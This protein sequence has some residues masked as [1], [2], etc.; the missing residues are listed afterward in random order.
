MARDEPMTLTQDL[1]Q[2]ESDNQRWA[3]DGG[4]APDPRPAPPDTL[5]VRP[6]YRRPTGAGPSAL[7]SAPPCTSIPT[8]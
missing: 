7:S 1:F 3:D 8:P 6:V 2:R 4:R 5:P